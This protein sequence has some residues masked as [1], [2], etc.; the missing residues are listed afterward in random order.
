VANKNPDEASE[1]L[2]LIG[3]NALDFGLESALDVA[4]SERLRLYTMP[5]TPGR[6]TAVSEQIADT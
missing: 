4:G 3:N 5:P 2:R 6:K 1:T